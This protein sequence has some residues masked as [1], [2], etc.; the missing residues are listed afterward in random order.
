MVHSEVLK[1]F[2]EKANIIDESS[3]DCW[4]MNGRDSIRVRFK[5]RTELVF[6]YHDERHWTLQTAEEFIKSMKEGKK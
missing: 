6:T 1:K 5:N 2:K 3:L 4:F